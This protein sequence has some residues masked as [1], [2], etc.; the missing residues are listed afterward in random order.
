MDNRE[1]DLAIPETRTRSQRDGD[2]RLVDAEDEDEK[3]TPVF[4]A[5]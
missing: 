1:F 3:E 4:T 5:Q 2:Q